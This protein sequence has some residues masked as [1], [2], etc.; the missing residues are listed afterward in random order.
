MDEANNYIT[1]FKSDAEKLGDI[2]AAG[3]RSFLISKQ[4]YIT[5]FKNK[6][7]DQYMDFYMSHYNN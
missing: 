1:A 6:D 4:N 7:I 3:Y 2:N 5:L